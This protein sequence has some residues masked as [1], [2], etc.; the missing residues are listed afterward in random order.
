MLKLPLAHLDDFELHCEV[1]HFLVELLE[2]HVGHAVV[3]LELRDV[4]DVAALQP[5]NL[6]ALPLQ[7]KHLFLLR[8][9]VIVPLPSHT[10]E[11]RL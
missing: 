2:V 8:K 11:R 3:V 1:V 7:L 10:H 5:R 6:V 4:S 9:Q